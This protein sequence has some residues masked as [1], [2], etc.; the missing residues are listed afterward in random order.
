M[1][2]LLAAE[3]PN[4]FWIP[5]DPKEFWWGLA[6]FLIVVALLWWKVLPLFK[7]GLATRADRI[8]EQLAAADKAQAAAD[9]E[10]AALRAKLADG[11]AEA[12]RI[13]ADAHTAAAKLKD[14]AKVRAASEVAALRERADAEIEGARRQ[15]QADLLAEANVATLTAAEEVVRGNL[16]DA[17]QQALIE[18]YIEQVG[19]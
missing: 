14:D 18:R 7:Q 8:E 6:A 2:S 5:G 4:G 11:D 1:W 13:V 10:L 3:K 12:Q 19:A 16:D 17:T 15:A 9:A